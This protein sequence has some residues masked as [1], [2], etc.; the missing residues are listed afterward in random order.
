MSVSIPLRLGVAAL[1]AAPALAAPLRPD[2]ADPAASVPKLQHRSA[3]ADYRR[4]ADP[5][6]ADWKGANQLVDRIGGWRAYAREAAQGA[7]SAPAP[8]QAHKH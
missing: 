3:L 8:A 2:P 5:P 4:H 7:A 6:P 1:L